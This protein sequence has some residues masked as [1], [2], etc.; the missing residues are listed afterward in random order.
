[1][2]YL[3]QN[4]P[5]YMPHMCQNLI[6]RTMIAST[7][8]VAVVGLCRAVEAYVSGLPFLSTV[9]ILPSVVCASTASPG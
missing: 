2:V 3:S 4:S 7:K 6:I 8:A 5:H 9:L 1:M